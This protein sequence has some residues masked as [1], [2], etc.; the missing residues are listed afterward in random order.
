MRKMAALQAGFLFVAMFA[1]ATSK[2][3]SMRIKV[4]D[5]ET[6]SVVLDNS[7][8]PKNCDQLNYDA[9]CH[10]SKVE[11]LT[12]T[13][14]VQ[15]SNG[16]QYRIAC[17]VESKWSRCIPLPKG[18]T[19]DARKE[20]HGITVYYQDDDGKPRRQLY[21]FVAADT[22]SGQAAP[23]AAVAPQL[24]AAPAQNAPPVPV[25]STTP[26]PAQNPAPAPA[27]AV[28]ASSMRET[29][30]CT[31]SSTPPG[32]EVTLDG[33]YVGSTPSV[34]GLTLGT[35]VVVISMPGFAQWKR[36][37][38]VAPGSELTVNAVLQKAQ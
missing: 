24:T 4:L 29:V 6:H 16:T 25:Q 33:R 10:S 30:K 21:T 19:F 20:K 1:N 17:T 12:T 11:Q 32:A 23:A 22:K 26:V 31:F 9:Y 8:V 34:L 14:L 37:L 35:H 13:L 28:A 38:A 3:T 36:E 18:E 7:G 27:A 15:D 2:N 5:S